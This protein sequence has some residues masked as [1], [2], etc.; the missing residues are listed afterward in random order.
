M[1]N[2]RP[3]LFGAAL[4]SVGVMD[5]LRFERFTGGQLWVGEYGDPAVEADF[6]DLLSYS[7]YHNVKANSAYPA[8]LVT[9]GEAD[10]RVVPAHSFKYVA[11]IQA[12]DSGSK[13]RLLRIDKRAGHGAGKPTTQVIEEA[14]D[15]WTFAARWTGLKVTDTQ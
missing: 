7:P 9:T 10:T 4:P 14:A 13:P 12:S 2:Q 11:A 8:I 5:M 6:H 3:E 1:V 15:M